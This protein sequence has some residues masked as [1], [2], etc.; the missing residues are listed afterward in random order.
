MFSYTWIKWEGNDGIE[1]ERNISRGFQ[2]NGLNH[3]ACTLSIPMNSSFNR[4]LPAGCS[5]VSNAKKAQKSICNG[6]KR[7]DF[8]FIEGL[9]S[10]NA[11]L[12]AKLRR[13]K[14]TANIL[15]LFLA[16]K[17]RL[18]HL[19]KLNCLETFQ[20]SGLFAVLFNLDVPGLPHDD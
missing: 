3:V 2:L 11:A 16:K 19:V 5:L 1:R 17:M 8:F 14:Q 4:E 15:L 9:A 12:T 20:L 18:C 7:M 6:L 13:I 10:T